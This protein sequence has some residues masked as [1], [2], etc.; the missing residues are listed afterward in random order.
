MVL[1][2]RGSITQIVIG[3]IFNLAYLLLQMQANPFNDIADDYLANSCSFALSVVF[4][5]SLMFK[6]ATL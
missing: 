5:C 6:I 4:V 3:I 2:V 1:V